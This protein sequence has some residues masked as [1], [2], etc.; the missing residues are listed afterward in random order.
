MNPNIDLALQLL[1]LQLWNTIYMVA[2]S[3][4]FSVLIGLPYRS[5]LNNNGQGAY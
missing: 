5:H 3:T 4:F 2:V 1:P